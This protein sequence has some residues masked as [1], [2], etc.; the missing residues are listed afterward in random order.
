MNNPNTPDQP[1][2]DVGVGGGTTPPV[3]VT[4]APGPPANMVASGPPDLVDACQIYNPN[5]PEF[6]QGTLNPFFYTGYHPLFKPC[7][8][9]ADCTELGQP[10]LNSGGEGC[11]LV[12]RCICDT[13]ALVNLGNAQCTG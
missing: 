4:P 9:N 6:F 13:S 2:L 7:F 12:D 8:N 3:S 11:C 10:F 1:P 5:N